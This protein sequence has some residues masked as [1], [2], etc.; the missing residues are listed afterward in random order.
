MAC[1]FFLSPWSA[2]CI[3]HP[4]LT[5]M[6][7]RW[8]ESPYSIDGPHVISDSRGQEKVPKP[9]SICGS[10]CD[11][12]LNKEIVRFVLE[13]TTTGRTFLNG[14]S[15]HCS[16]CQNE[17]HFRWFHE[18]SNTCTS[19]SQASMAPEMEVPAFFLTM[20]F[21]TSLGDDCV[22]GQSASPVPVVVLRV[23]LSYKHFSTFS[24]S[25]SAT[26]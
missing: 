22:T 24:S 12:T 6:T 3:P 9:R 15:R 25:E 17:S 20:Q 2:H 19:L 21:S 10:S 18:L 11:Y 1:S 23:R 13:Y 14:G 16:P 8:S 7:P 5:S 26:V 4:A